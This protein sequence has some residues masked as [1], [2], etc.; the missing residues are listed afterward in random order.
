MAEKR[1]AGDARP[2]M[3]AI[4][5]DPLAGTPQFRQ[6]YEGLAQAIR[7]GQFAPGSRLP[8]T[9]ALAGHLGVA[10]NTAHL[11]FEQ[12]IAEGYVEGRIGAGTF[13][14]SA[15]PE[16]LLQVEP[17]GPIAQPAVNSARPLSRRTA[18]LLSIYPREPWDEA[19][20]IRAFRVTPA[21]DQFPRALWQRLLMRSWR[22]GGA[23]LLDYGWGHSGLRQ[24]IAEYL[25]TARGVRCT[26]DNVIVVAGEQQGIDLAIRVLVEEGQRAWIED[27]GDPTAYG[28]L[29]SAG[30]EPVPVPVDEEGLDVASGIRTAAKARLA[31]VTP[32]CQFPMGVTMSLR[33]RLELLDWAKTARAWIIEDDYSSEY[34]YAG[35]PLAALQGLDREQRVIYLGTFSKVMFPALRLAYLIVPRDL[36]H[37]FLV[38]RFFASRHPPRLEQAAL[39]RF[40]ADGHFARHV[41]RMRTLYARRQQTLI[42]ALE[43]D[44]IP[45]IG[46]EPAPAGLHLLGRLPRKVNDREIS[47]ELAKA[48]IDARPLSEFAIKRKLPPALI[49]GYAGVNERAIRDGVR[50]L[51]RVL[52][53][54]PA[55]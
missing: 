19:G 44:P 37:A 10:R 29:V 20:R 50:T 42:A 32:S 26:A 53:D 49:L 28:A 18:K 1:E 21:L 31:Y 39:A 5:V 4:I 45:A 55:A 14:A 48:G 23:E 36:I 43:R 11:A 35:R 9:R 41:R 38:T 6:L 34:R 27:P 47:G 46:I 54:T 2:F 8:S 16:Q 17:R 22:E 13:V 3:P 30:A 33:R 40:I 52:R 12:L 24:A 7:E 15:L 51:R 25:G